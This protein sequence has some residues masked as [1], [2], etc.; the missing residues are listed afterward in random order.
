MDFLG[1]RKKAK[2][3]AAARAR[4][5]EAGKPGPE[6]RPTPDEPGPPGAPPDTVVTDA[7]VLEGKLMAELQGPP[8]PPAAAEMPPGGG[9]DDFFI[10]ARGP[11]TPVMQDDAA[12]LSGLLPADRP[13][14]RAPEAEARPSPPGSLD[15]FFFREDEPGSPILDPGL[16]AAERPESPAQPEARKEYLGF[17]LG[18]EEYALEIESVREILRA[19]PIAEVPRAPQDV[20]GVVTV[21]GEVIPVLDPRRRLDLP[22]RPAGAGH[23]V[24]ICQY[25]G[26]S[27]GV[28]VDRV[29]QV[30]RL[31]PSA[32][33]TRPQG[34]GRADP[35]TIAGI[36]R[37]RDRLLIILDPAALL[38]TG[39]G[40]GSERPA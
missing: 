11:R 9:E 40:G 12:A 13:A 25:R 33:E 4:E 10:A 5:A 21:R 14:G 1:I 28:L 32:I 35:A 23:R 2:E 20:L 31:P 15:E 30:V 7:D 6:P 22:A 38:G 3:R 39:A 16:A 8:P 24:V 19:P 36:G 34:I 18:E 37:E 17:F 29:S 26:T 27:V